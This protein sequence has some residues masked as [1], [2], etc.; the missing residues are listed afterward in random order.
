MRRKSIYRQVVGMAVASCLLLNSCSFAPKY[1]RPEMSLEGGYDSKVMDVKGEKKAE[2]VSNMTWNKFFTDPVLQEL[3]ETGLENN[4]NLQKALSRVAE[5]KA[6]LGIQKADLFPQLDGSGNARRTEFSDQTAIANPSLVSDYGL[7]GDLFFEID[8]WG[9][10]RNLTEAERTRFFAT[11]YAYQSVRITLVSEIARTY[12]LILDLDNRLKISENTY[13]SR[14]ESLKI[15]NQRFKGGIIAETDVNQAEILEGDALATLAQTERGLGLAE[16]AMNILLGET[17]KKIKRGKSLDDQD[18]PSMVET[19]F[20]TELLERRP[21]IKSAEELV[22]S[23]LARVGVAKAERLP[24]LSLVGFIG[25]QSND[26]LEF[27][28]GSTW[29]IGGNALGPIIDFGKRKSGVKAAEARALQAYQAYEQNVIVAVSEVDDALISIKTY[30]L[31]NRA[32]EAQAKAATNSVKLSNARYD[33]GVTTYLEVLDIQ[34]SLFN[35]QLSSSQTKQQYLS[36]IVQLYK[37][38]GGGWDSEQK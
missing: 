36:S 30:D 7:S 19:G 5:A 28:D 14:Q 34:R 11:E 12:F 24:K 35:A 3:I 21:D 20:P 38:L 16:N 37:A 8:L 6:V 26:S 25:L 29:S 1:F 9:R 13:K 4:R 10:V 17:S 27:L 31:E 22:K 33:N 2:V 32:R 15:I 18:F 23:E